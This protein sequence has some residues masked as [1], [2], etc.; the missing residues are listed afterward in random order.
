MAAYEDNVGD[1]ITFAETFQ[2]LE[3]FVIDALT[4]TDTKTEEFGHNVSDSLSFA[5][6]FEEVIKRLTA[7]LE[8]RIYVV[9][10]LSSEWTHIGSFT[11]DSQTDLTWTEI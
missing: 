2:S 1:T 11:E 9:D 10:S 6:T 8:D 5:E 3:D 7:Y 4:I